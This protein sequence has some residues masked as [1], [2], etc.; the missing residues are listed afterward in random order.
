MAV[1]LIVAV[2]FIPFRWWAIAALVG[3]GTMEG[4]GLFGG[5][6]AHPPLTQVIHRFVPP[7]LSFP[8]MW[9]LW[10]AAVET[11]R[12]WMNP[13]AAFAGLALLGFL[14]WHFV[15]TYQQVT[16]RLSSLRPRMPQTTIVVSAPSPERQSHS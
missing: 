4:F 12:I 6:P 9:G 14:C 15:Q 11:W 7:I 1:G 2:W 13:F 10:G 16:A 8:L 5:N 3:F